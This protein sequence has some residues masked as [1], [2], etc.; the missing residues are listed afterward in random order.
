MDEFFA[1]H[2]EIYRDC[3]ESDSFWESEHQDLNNYNFNRE[4]VELTPEQE[5]ELTAIPF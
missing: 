5:I 4:V 2:D 1:E 3:R